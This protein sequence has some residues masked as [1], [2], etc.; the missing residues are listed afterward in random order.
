M[1][2][3]INIELISTFTC[4]RCEK[5]QKDVQNMIKSLNND[6]ILYREV[7]VLKQL[8][9]V[10]K[11][12]VLQTPAI[13]INGKLIFRCIPSQSQFNKVLEKFLYRDLDL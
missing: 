1:N 6:D 10:V 3:H 9:Y 7:N 12:G 5:A 8:D 2:H 13:A 11:L 4:R